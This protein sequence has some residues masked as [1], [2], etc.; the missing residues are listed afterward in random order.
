[1]E[2]GDA[3]MLETLDEMLGESESL[4]RALLGSGSSR[5]TDEELMMGPPEP[6]VIVGSRPEY[7]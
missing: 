3:V 1:M 4:T 6:G 7:L 5:L 2:F